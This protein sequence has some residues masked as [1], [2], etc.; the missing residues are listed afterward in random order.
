L[1]RRRRRA[2]PARPNVISLGSQKLVR[3]LDTSTDFV[4]APRRSS[5]GLLF[6]LPLVFRK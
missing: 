4:P 6:G 2:R 5:C 1:R 3:A